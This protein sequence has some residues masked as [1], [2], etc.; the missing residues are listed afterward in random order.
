[1]GKKK[2]IDAIKLIETAC[3]KDLKWN[4]EN[5]RCEELSD[6]NV[7]YLFRIINKE[8]R[9]SVVIKIADSVTRVKPDGHI[10]PE[11]NFLEA[12]NMD[13]FNHNSEMVPKDVP[14]LK[15][16]KI[17]SVNEAKHYFLMEDIVP[18]ITLRQA[19]MQAVMPKD[20]GFRFATFIA[21]SQIPYIEL[22]ERAP[23]MDEINLL[24]DD[25]IKI[26]EDLVFKAPFFDER[27][28]NIYTKGNEEFLRNEI[29]N[30]KRLRFVSA[31]YLNKFKTYKQSL[32]HGDLHT[33]SVLVKFDGE[34]I[35][36]KPSNNMDMFVID[37]EFAS[38]APIAYDV[39]NVIAHLVIADM[40]NMVKPNLTTK[41]RME[42]HAYISKE[43]DAF[44]SAFR[45]I[46]YSILR[47]EIENPLYRSNR[48][49]KRYIEDI[50]NDA[51]KFAGLE[52]IRRVVG[53]AKVPELEKIT[54]LEA[55]IRMERMIVKAAKDFVFSKNKINRA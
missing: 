19:L 33:G 17:L 22:V 21:T 30:D 35:V 9:E 55:K 49:V 37:A 6:G 52:M 31:K 1:M 41:K 53:S 48:F 42:F 26:T 34:K 46:S 40:Y 5:V 45:Q 28:R 18:S 44:V 20:L 51:W 47:R 2:P 7:N 24:N 15:V 4:Y 16:P 38:F 29:T 27:E 25:L 36:G 3:K 43:M 11:R 54:D 14:T 8:T 13:W 39:G 10:D 50:I 12:E 23:N 32:I